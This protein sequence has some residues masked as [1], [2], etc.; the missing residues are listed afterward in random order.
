MLVHVY[1]NVSE[2]LRGNQ[3]VQSRE[4]GNTRQRKTNQKH[5]KKCA[6]NHYRQTSINEVNKTISLLQTTG[7]KD[8]KFKSE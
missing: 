2:Y 4:T 7:G 8:S 6:G 3:N 1:I 5:N